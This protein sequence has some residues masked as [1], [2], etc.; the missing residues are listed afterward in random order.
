MAK[1]SKY[2]PSFRARKT[3]HQLVQ[4]PSIR[5]L[6]PSSLRRRVLPHLPPELWIAIAE[7]I[8]PADLGKLL[9]LNRFFYNLVLDMRYR[10][11]RLLELYPYQ[12]LKK[13]DYLKW[14]LLTIK[15]LRY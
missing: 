12:F 14:V 7:L 9:G 4:G 13:I 1:Y 15:V 3:S 10:E 11:L 8:D 2:L 5:S 6:I